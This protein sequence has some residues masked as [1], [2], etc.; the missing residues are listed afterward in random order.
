MLYYRPLVFESHAV[1]LTVVS[2]NNHGKYP[3]DPV[4]KVLE[5]GSSPNSAMPERSS[6]F[7][8][9]DG[10]DS[11]ARTMRISNLNRYLESIQAR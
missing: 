4:I 5:N 1:D 2:K 9:I 10:I 6:V 11:A 3:T 7:A 8:K